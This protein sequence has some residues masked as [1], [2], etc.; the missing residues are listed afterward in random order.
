[1]TK[2]KVGRN[3]PCP[4][5]S[6]QKYKK[7]C[8]GK[9]KQPSRFRW[10]T[11]PE[12]VVVG[13]LLESSEQFRAF[14][15]DQRGKII[16]PLHWAQDLSLPEG[17]DYRCTRFSTGERVIRLRR[18][19]PTL[20]DAMSVAHELQHVILDSEGFPKIASKDWQYETVASTLN[21]MVHDPLVDSQLQKY[22]LDLQ[23]K[24]R[25]E[26]R[27]DIRQLE[28][29]P[30]APTNHLGKMH[31][32]FNY[33]GKIL[34]WELASEKAES[35]V[36]EFQSWFDARYP[37]VAAEGQELLDLVKSVGFDTPEK[38]ST[39]FDEIIRRYKLGVFLFVVVV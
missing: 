31:W 14:Y 26:E 34:D 20:G 6:G 35:T 27:E 15:Q 25:K 10:P 16:E 8:L 32:M 39:L 29:L 22:G 17:I 21:S 18:V 19:P 9:L 12:E 24:L 37:D 38:M 1:M 5:G 23:E 30:D 13:G 2:G 36:G 33:V 3:D 11:F 28:A 7:C 4:C